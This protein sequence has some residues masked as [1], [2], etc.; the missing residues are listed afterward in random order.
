MEFMEKKRKVEHLLRVK[1]PFSW[2]PPPLTPLRGPNAG[3]GQHEMHQRLMAKV[4]TERAELM[5]LPDDEIERRFITAGTEEQAKAAMRAAIEEKGRFFSKREAE[6]D[7]AYWSKVEY[8]TIDESIAL[9][10]G[11]SPEVVTWKSIQA[12]VNVSAFAKQY[13]RLRNLALRAQAM[14]RGQS[15]VYPN[16]VLAWAD[17]VEIPVPN[18]LR[19]SLERQWAKKQGLPTVAASPV[20]RSEVPAEP[21]KQAAAVAAQAQAALAE[22]VETPSARRARRL[23]RFREL[24]GEMR[25]A[26]TGWQTTGTRGALAALIREEVEAGRPMADKT[27]VR[28]DLASAMGDQSGDARGN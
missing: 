14:N 1:F 9:L 20:A 7:F 28:A 18:A 12:Y 23:R 2:A 25:K 16:V 13:E 26:G 4:E 3:L 19:E 17:E 21:S 24:G 8:W 22:S 11:K 15:A 10:L 5:A 27:D 6:A